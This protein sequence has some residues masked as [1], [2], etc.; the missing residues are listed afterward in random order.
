ME[1]KFE[2]EEITGFIGRAAAVLAFVGALALALR[3]IDIL[4]VLALLEPAAHTF[5]IVI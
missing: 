3:Q 5:R 1:V 4:E 2:M